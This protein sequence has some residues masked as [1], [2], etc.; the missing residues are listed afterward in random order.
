MHVVI[1]FIRHLFF[2]DINENLNLG[3]TQKKEKR[4]M[5]ADPLKY[6]NNS[7]RKWKVYADTFFHSNGKLLSYYPSSNIHRC[8]YLSKTFLVGRCHWK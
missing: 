8:G 2:G 6:M 5:I 7:F 1:A 4:R 3:S